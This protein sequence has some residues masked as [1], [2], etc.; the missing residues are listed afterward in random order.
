MA[1]ACLRSEIGMRRVCPD[2]KCSSLAF[3]RWS[4]G[5]WCLYIKSLSCARGMRTI[6]IYYKLIY[7]HLNNAWYAPTYAR[8]TGAASNDCSRHMFLAHGVCAL[9]FARARQSNWTTALRIEH[10]WPENR[11]LKDGGIKHAAISIYTQPII[12]ICTYI[13]T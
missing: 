3:A 1:K 4:A 6:Y 8:C 7:F 5:N 11:Y 9:H 2:G 12:Y 13:H 10:N